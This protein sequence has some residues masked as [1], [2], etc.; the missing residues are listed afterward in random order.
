MK[1]DKKILIAFILNFCFSI[2]NFVGGIVTGSV[3]ILSDAVHDFGDSLSI[4]T[5]AVCEKVSKK[6]P[7]ERYTYGYYRYSV[8]GGVIQ[9]VILLC[10][11]IFVIYNAVM[12]LINPAPINYN[13][14]I[15][16]AIVGFIVNF[17]ATYFT[18]GGKSLNEKAINL[19]MLEDVLGWVIVLVGAIVMRFTDWSFLDPILSITLAIFIVINAGKTLKTVIDIFLEKTPKNVDIEKIKDELLSIE[20]VE[21]V[22]H[23]H[24]WSMDGYNNAATLHVVSNANLHLIKDKV[25]EKLKQRKIVH[26]TIECENVGEKCHEDHC[27][28]IAF[29][30]AHGHH[31][32]HHH[33]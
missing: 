31:H 5:S 4:G 26:C 29:Q 1:S 33:H 25:R 11:S 17:V 9:S 19:H 32:H 6:E 7:N 18:S 28:S 22:H 3:A 23:V 21:G 12:R 10:G 15:I 14:V 20:G 27:E 8:L 16:I 24:I 30:E 13:G 2:V